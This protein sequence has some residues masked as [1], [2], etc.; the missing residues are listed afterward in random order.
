VSAKV[1]LAG[2]LPGDEEIN[3]LDAI[4]SK[5]IEQPER[6]R[7]C[8]VWVDVRKIEDM[9]DTGERIP[10]ARVRRIEYAG[11]AKDAPQELRDLALR[12]YEERT[13]KSP[14][15]I[16]QLARPTDGPVE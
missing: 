1:R 10:V 4:A 3:G 7:L 5:L 15:P 6:L 16:D 13:G 2:A 8:L 14:L 9:T 11:D 12:L